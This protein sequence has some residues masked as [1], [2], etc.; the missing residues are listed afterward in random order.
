[1]N[2]CLEIGVEWAPDRLVASRRVAADLAGEALKSP[3]CLRQIAEQSYL[4]PNGFRKI[5]LARLDAGAALRLHCWRFAPHERPDLRWEDI[6]THRWPFASLVLEG[7]LHVREYYEEDSPHP[8]TYLRYICSPNEYGSYLFTPDL[9]V[10]LSE[11]RLRVIN[12]HQTYTTQEYTAHAVASPI[13]RTTTLVFQGVPSR[14]FSYLYSD[15]TMQEVVPVQTT[16][17]LSCEE[18]EQELTHFLNLLD[19]TPQ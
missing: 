8:P 12:S 15:Q 14:K 3:P 18:V 17:A 19:Q 10:R 16:N 4:H 13:E 6:H 11:P 2:A 5:V 7:Q 9:P 1:M